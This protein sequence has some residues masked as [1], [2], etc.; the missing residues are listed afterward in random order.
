M[1]SGLL[2]KAISLIEQNIAERPKDQRAIANTLLSLISVSPKDEHYL[3]STA[4]YAIASLE[5]AL[6][7][8]K[9]QIERTEKEIL[10]SFPT[11]EK[12]VAAAILFEKLTPEETASASRYLRTLIDEIPDSLEKYLSSHLK[13]ASEPRSCASAG[14]CIGGYLAATSAYANQYY[15]DFRILTPTPLRLSDVVSLV[16]SYYEERGYAIRI[17]GEN[18]LMAQGMEYLHFVSMTARDEDVWVS[19]TRHDR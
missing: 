3:K 17:F 5:E 7:G 1:N 10:V 18:S 9:G 13:L 12:A 11:L 8:K 15:E 2:Q 16:I 14:S 4:F 19:I 6:D